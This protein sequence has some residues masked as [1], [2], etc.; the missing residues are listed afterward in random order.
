MKNKGFTLIEVLSIMV[1]L[2]VIAII[3]IPI[4][5]DEIEK[6]RYGAFK[7]S[8]LSIF[9]AADYQVLNKDLTK[10]L[11]VPDMKIEH[12]TFISGTAT[13]IN[14]S[15][16]IENVGDGFYCANGTLT[17][18][19]IE[20][21]ECDPSIPSC[22]F[23][24]D[25]EENEFGWYTSEVK[26]LMKTSTAEASGIEYG[27]GNE[28]N[29]EYVV[30]KGEYGRIP[31]VINDI[32]EV[33]Y[34]CYVKTGV[35]RKSENKIKL[36]VDTKKPT[37]PKIT[38]G[39]NEWKNENIKISVSEESTSLSGIKKYQYVISQTEEIK[40]DAIWEDVEKTSVEI[41]KEG[42]N[43]IYFR[44]VNNAGVESDVS[45][46]Q[47]TKIDKVEPKIVSNRDLNI[48]TSVI[49]DNL[50][51][52][53][54]AVTKSIDTP[55]KWETIGGK[56]VTKTYDIKEAGTY[57]IHVIDESG[58]SSF[59]KVEMSDY[60][61][62]LNPN[63]GS[64]SISSKKVLPGL[65]YGQLPTPTKS[66]YTFTGWY[67]QATAG[68]KIDATTKVTREENHTLYSQWKL[69]NL[70]LTNLGLGY[71]GWSCGK[72]HNGKCKHV[73]I[74]QMTSSINLANYKTL[75][76]QGT[77]YAQGPNGAHSKL[78]YSIDTNS[79]KS[80]GNWVE[81]GS[82]WDGTYNSYINKSINI[83]GYNSNYYIKIYF[84]YWMNSAHNTGSGSWSPSSIYL[85]P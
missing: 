67:T 69:S 28:E 70:S 68:T 64:T 13:L 1:I 51:L 83:S 75:V 60:T 71:M 24:T 37:T 14:R 61:I 12:N 26:L 74:Y 10:T 45:N 5:K 85:V 18:L 41:T 55:T 30:K 21:G 36:K 63:G 53:G 54:Y 76:I 57:Y 52:V 84:Y 8:V 19:K 38:G 4:I 80:S 81:I 6:S 3:T 44:A 58:L 48:I 17:D 42:T 34:S 9:S 72:D 2:A 65:T 35:G 22:Y 11:K 7:S 43:Y 62:T 50:N 47:I 39:S 23:L 40:E 32:E 16:V 49:E 73:K 59:E 66:G 77:L 56:K 29:Y 46:Y 31:V 78:Y 33:E 79:N 25:V 20:R 15:W 82:V 27:I